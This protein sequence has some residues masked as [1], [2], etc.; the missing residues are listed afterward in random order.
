MAGQRTASHG[1]IGL[2]TLSLLE[3][4]ITAKSVLRCF[5]KQ[6]LVNTNPFHSLKSQCE[7]AVRK[8]KANMLKTKYGGHTDGRTDG[9]TD[10]VSDD[11]TP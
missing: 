1:Q 4:L 5:K 2:L 3:M 6:K 8:N 7:N 11:V 9:R 10:G